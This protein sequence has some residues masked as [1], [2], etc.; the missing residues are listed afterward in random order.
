MKSVV[1]QLLLETQQLLL[2]E[3]PVSA[4]EA[5]LG[6]ALFEVDPRSGATH[7]L[8]LWKDHPCLAHDV[9]RASEDLAYAVLRAF[10]SICSTLDGVVLE[11]L[12]VAEQLLSEEDSRKLDHYLAGREVQFDAAYDLLG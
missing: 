1:S 6:E 8:L 5:F 11:L 10:V 7:A 2:G 3:F 9:D 12:L 4:G